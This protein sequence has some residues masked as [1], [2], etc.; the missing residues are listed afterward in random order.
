MF[1]CQNLNVN[2][3]VAAQKTNFIFQRNAVEDLLADEFNDLK[4]LPY[5][6]IV[7][8]FIDKNHQRTSEY[9]KAIK[10][11]IEKEGKTIKKVNSLRW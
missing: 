5:H 6:E 9:E 8:F 4:D 11:A 2:L 1:I 7:H 3:F 10:R